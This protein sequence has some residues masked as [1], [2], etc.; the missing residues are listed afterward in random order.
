[1][2]WGFWFWWAWAWVILK[3]NLVFVVDNDGRADVITGA[4]NT[5][6]PHV[7]A[8]TMDGPIDSINFFAYS[9]SFRGGVDVAGGSW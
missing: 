5:G 6:G 1:M 8:F 4:G 2:G 7:R 3:Q 9:E